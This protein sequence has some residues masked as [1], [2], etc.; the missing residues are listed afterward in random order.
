MTRWGDKNSL[1][2]VL[3]VPNGQGGTW[4]GNRNYQSVVPRLELSGRSVGC[5]ALAC[6]PY[7][8]GT[9]A[10]NG[11][12][13]ALGAAMRPVRVTRDKQALTGTQKEHRRNYTTQLR[14]EGRGSTDP[15]KTGRDPV[16]QQSR[17]TSQGKAW[18]A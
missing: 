14:T 16:E 15:C 4:S 9:Q 5:G 10:A 6:Q 8:Q 7:R 13:S 12:L 2:V 17:M 1:P 3:G 18:H 11:A